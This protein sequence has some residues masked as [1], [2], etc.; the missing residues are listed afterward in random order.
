MTSTVETLLTLEP[1]AVFSSVFFGTAE[2][3]LAGGAGAYDE[4]EEAAGLGVEVPEVASE[5][6]W[7]YAAMRAG[8]NAL[9][10]SFKRGG[11]A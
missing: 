8:R 10:F 9:N 4:D 1:D 7:P 5:V 2:A 6:G 3:S 11:S